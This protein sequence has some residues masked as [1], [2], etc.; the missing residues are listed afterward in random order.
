MKW[1]HLK[2]ENGQVLVLFL[3]ILPILILGILALFSYYNITYEKKKLKHI[4][5]IG[6]QV[7]LKNKEET[8][9]RELIQKNDSTIEE[10]KVE[11]N[12]SPIKIVLKK[13]ISGLFLNKKSTIQIS[14]EC[15]S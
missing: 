12:H 11:W 15:T 7:V 6:C 9:L 8:K 3:L 13:E 4:A 14:V 10:I 2:S 1:N 5:E